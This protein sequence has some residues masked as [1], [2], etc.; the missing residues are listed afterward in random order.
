M[1]FAAAS[2]LDELCAFRMPTWR[3]AAPFEVRLIVRRARSA[4]VVLCI[5]Q[6]RV[7]L[8]CRPWR[9]VAL[10]CGSRLPWWV[11]VVCCV[12]ASLL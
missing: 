5:L 2:G 6:Y 3:N 10:S 9:L 11:E 4:D 7:K 1:T 8:I 12:D